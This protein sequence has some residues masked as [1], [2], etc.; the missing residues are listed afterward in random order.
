MNTYLDLTAYMTY[1]TLKKHLIITEPVIE[2][3]LA[4]GYED[5]NEFKDFL[6][7]DCEV[8]WDKYLL[9]KMIQVGK[10]STIHQITDNK[11]YY[12]LKN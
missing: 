6:V 3:M 11:M 7:N 8:D 10:V 12:A 9:D 1:E 2:D 5:T 4:N